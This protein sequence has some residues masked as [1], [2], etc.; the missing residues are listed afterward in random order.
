MLTKSEQVEII[1]FWNIKI[2]IDINILIIIYNM[3][4]NML[5]KSEQVEDIKFWNINI[6]V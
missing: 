5:T 2:N 6:N 1:K 4:K 3:L